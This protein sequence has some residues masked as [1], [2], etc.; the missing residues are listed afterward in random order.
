MPR[1]PSIGGRRYGSAQADAVSLEL[2]SA[3]Q[4]V[5]RT[6]TAPGL[7]DGTA[8]GPGNRRTHVTQ[9]PDIAAAESLELHSGAKGRRRRHGEPDGQDK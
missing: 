1:L 7:F 8:V 3:S 6:F 2:S 5:V 9:P 4:V